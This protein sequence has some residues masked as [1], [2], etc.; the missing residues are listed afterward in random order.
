MVDA[1]GA[2]QGLPPQ[3]AAGA[4]GGAANEAG[5][6]HRT[7]VAVHMVVAALTDAAVP[8]ALPGAMQ[9]SDGCG[10]GQ[11]PVAIRVET[12]LATDDIA[13]DLLRGGRILLQAKLKADK[14][15]LREVLAGQWLPAVQD[16]AWRDGTALVL[17]AETATRDVSN[18]GA[19]L[20]RR[21][22]PL[23]GAPSVLDNAAYASWLE[24][25]N[26]LLAP[27][28]KDSADQARQ[29]LEAAVTVWA[30]RGRGPASDGW[31][32]QT[33]RLA[34]SV[35][36]ARQAAD[37]VSLLA[38]AVRAAAQ[39]RT[40][41]RVHD[42]ARVLLD[43]SLDVLARPGGITGARLAAER[44]ALDAYRRSLAAR[45]N[46]IALHDLGVSLPDVT[47]AGLAAGI[48]V[49]DP[50]DTS[51]SGAHPGSPLLDEARGCSR[52]MVLGQGGAGKSQA[53]TQLAAFAA[54][55]AAARAA[56]PSLEDHWTDLGPWAPLPILVPLTASAAP[57]PTPTG[58]RHRRTS[59]C[60]RRRSAR[61]G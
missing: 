53:L 34:D 24:C 20:A 61:Q 31:K 12:D 46:K 37:A 18:L 57:R 28:S 40:G 13:V 30:F 32:L 16:P 29:R 17:V 14:A 2:R 48:M 51:A 25:L 9:P 7:A 33:A 45:L 42:W 26:P 21:W 19:A 3:A 60:H 52:G 44:N 58:H 15:Q 8:E 39:R 36:P 10:P 38:E 54:D 41:G 22:D 56:D 59:H 23:A 55:P 50:D 5:S 1:A 49:H 43:S 35:V 27:L 47:V 6:A 11:V 4:L